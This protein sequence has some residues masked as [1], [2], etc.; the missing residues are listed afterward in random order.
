VT[1]VSIVKYL[2]L[3]QKFSRDQFMH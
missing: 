2:L 3:G 1:L